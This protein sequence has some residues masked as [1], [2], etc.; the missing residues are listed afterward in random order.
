MRKFFFLCLFSA[1]VVSCAPQAT[2]A[3]G[4][5]T[6]R[7][8]AVESFLADF[9]RQVAGERASVDT[10][11][12]EGLDPHAFAPAP[13]DVAR[14]ADA[15]VLVVNGAGLEDWLSE[16][17]DTAGGSRALIEASAGLQSRP[18]PQDGAVSDPH[19]GA[20]DPH[21]WLDPTLAIHYVENIRD[22]LTQADPQ[23]KEIYARNAAAYIAQLQDLD[24]WIQSQVAQIAPQKRLIVTN[25]E[26]F[27]Y[28]ADRYGFR[29]IGA[30]I[31]SVSSGSAP[32]A[33]QLAQL[34]DAIRTNGATV[35][36]LETGANPNLA[37]Q[38]AAETGVSVVSDLY[39]HSLT[40]ANGPAPSYLEMMRY[41][42][43]LIVNALK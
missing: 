15:Q 20:G 6:L 12:P 39:T 13:A 43:I 11:I 25:H 38:I 37:Q 19:Q 14:V 33:Q 1:L 35:I 16:T 31:P 4:A 18:V 42:T 28:Y 22:G 3:A 36:F 40:A 27:G 30:I 8:L 2:Q 21:F 24:A 32:S 26:S 34:I 9:T 41:N 5:S 7:V 17:L 23:G 29:I 10:L